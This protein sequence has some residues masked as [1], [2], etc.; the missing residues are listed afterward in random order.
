MIVD[1]A[2]QA[3][4]AELKR[5]GTAIQKA[6]KRAYS[7]M[8]KKWHDYMASFKEREKPYLDRLAKAMQSGNGKEIGAAKRSYRRFL[9]QHTIQ[10]QEYA[11]IRDQLAAKLANIDKAA[12]E[13]VN[14]RLSN[15]YALNYNYLAGELPKAYAYGLITP[16]TV[17]GLLDRQLDFWKAKAYNADR[18]NKEVLQGILQ[19]ESMQKIAGR[20]KN[21]FGG[22]MADAMR[23]ARTAVT[24]A[25]NNGRFDSYLEAEAK[26]IVMKKVWTATHDSRTRDS[27][28]AIDGEMVD[29]NQTFGNGLRFPGDPDGRPEEVY[30]CRCAMGAR[31]IGFKDKN[32]VIIYV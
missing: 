23:Y 4:D 6:Y 11:R 28:S 3:T 30:N 13:I 19:G 24:Y 22:S 9:T 26:G 32:G 15:V 5:I 21:V 7:E 1:A 17:K 14:G 16:Q 29:L 10:S 8:Y 31:I 18:M 20:F 27:H 2:R 25:E 12:R